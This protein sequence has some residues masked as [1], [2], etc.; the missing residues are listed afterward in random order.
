MTDRLLSPELVSQPVAHKISVSLKTA[1][2]F[3]YRFPQETYYFPTA[4]AGGASL[5]ELT[6]HVKIGSCQ[7]KVFGQTRGKVIVFLNN[8]PGT[9][10]VETDSEGL[11]ASVVKGYRPNWR[12]LRPGEPLPPAF[13]SFVVRPMRDLISGPYVPFAQ[14]VT[15]PAEDLANMVRFAFIKHLYKERGAE[16]MR[17]AEPQGDTSTSAEEQYKRKAM[18]TGLIREF[19]RPDYQATGDRTPIKVTGKPLSEEIIEERR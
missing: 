11:Y 2:P 19:A 8:Y 4:Y 17:P 13:A 3:S 14:A 7:V 15:V 10:F 6:F 18:E 9:E 16:A 1:Q 12:N 5:E